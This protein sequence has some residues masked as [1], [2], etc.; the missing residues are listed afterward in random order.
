MANIR[1][2]ASDPELA[3]EARELFVRAPS[4]ERTRL[5]LYLKREGECWAWDGP[6]D[7]EAYGLFTYDRKTRRAHRVTYA[8]VNGRIPKGLVLDHLCRATHCVKPSHLEAVSNWTN[9]LR[10]DDCPPK[11]NYLKTECVNGHP[12]TTDN[13]YFHNGARACKE[14]VRKSVGR[15]RAK[16]RR[17]P[18]RGETRRDSK[19]TNTQVWDIKRRLRGGESKPSIAKLVGVSPKVIY[20][21]D[22]NITWKHIPWPD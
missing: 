3:E 16:R 13:T 10:G 7:K 5:L 18:K 19:L 15:Y 1:K 8:W 20:D 4:K 9:V 2:V 12:F 11:T 22:R 21:I 17:P 14:C 6:R